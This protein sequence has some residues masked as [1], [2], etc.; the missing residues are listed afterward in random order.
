MSMTRGPSGAA[1]SV[2]SQPPATEQVSQEVLVLE[3]GSSGTKCGFAGEDF[4]RAK[5]DTVEGRDAWPVQRG[6]V[7]NWEA[8]EDIWDRAFTEELHVSPRDHPVLLTSKYFMPKR[9]PETQAS[10]LFETFNVP[11]MHIM[12]EGTLALYAA[13][14]TTGVVL[15][16]GHGVT[17]V[18]CHYEGYNTRHGAIQ[19]NYGGI[20]LDTRLCNMLR[21]DG[22]RSELPLGISRFAKERVAYVALDFQQE[23]QFGKADK[24]FHLP[25]GT[26]FALGNERFRCVE[27]LFNQ[28]ALASDGEEPMLFDFGTDLQGLHES[29][30]RC[31]RRSDFD[32]DI[33]NDL[34]AE[35]VLTGGTTLL[36]GFRD[37]LHGELTRE[38]DSAFKQSGRMI[39]PRVRIN[40]H[41]NPRY[42]V[43]AGGSCLASLST[44]KSMLIS[45]EEYEES[46]P[47]IVHRKCEI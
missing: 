20:D 47:T 40:A 4:I 15:D 19:H 32:P 26:P 33:K 10:I 39:S 45:S 9:Q 22:I 30:L 1:K 44:F 41:S 37:R 3:T 36:P 31:V 42:A 28:G 6:I 16:V 43:F 7:R 2:P 5:F 24:A 34:Y 18:S 21:S 11:A 8:M 27:G 12:H 29:V 38:L 46:G 23:M 17:S 25:D 13:G 14:N 35:I